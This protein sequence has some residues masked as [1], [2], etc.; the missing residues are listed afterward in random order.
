MHT[1]CRVGDAFMASGWVQVQGGHSSSPSKPVR[2]AWRCVRL[3]GIVAAVVG[4]CRSDRGVGQH[5]GD[6]L[7]QFWQQFL[8]E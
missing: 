3:R 7:A 6:P 1:S 2:R 8:L 5:L 4:A